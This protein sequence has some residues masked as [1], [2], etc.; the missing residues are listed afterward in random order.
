MQTASDAL[1]A[2]ARGADLLADADSEAALAADALG[3]GLLAEAASDTALEAAVA[4][5]AAAD[6]AYPVGFPENIVLADGRPGHRPAAAFFRSQGRC[7][8]DRATAAAREARRQTRRLTDQAA[9]AG[10]NTDDWPDPPPA[11]ACGK[12][13]LAA[14]PRG[15][16]RLTRHCTLAGPEAAAADRDTAAAAA[17]RV[18]P[19]APQVYVA[20]RAALRDLQRLIPDTPAMRTRVAALRPGGSSLMAVAD[21]VLHWQA[22]EDQRAS[23]LQRLGGTHVG[24]HCDRS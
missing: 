3:A 13:Q 22:E 7:L 1:A 23:R 9:R 2:D 17:D 19:T 5:R 14:D 11:D 16:A 18:A 24:S 20:L 4:A 10:A 21:T 15:T 6:A 8:S 12:R